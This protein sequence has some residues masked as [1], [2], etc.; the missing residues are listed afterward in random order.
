MPFITHG[1]L[2]IPTNRDYDLGQ[3]L[4]LLLNLMDETEKIPVQAKVVWKTPAGS[5]NFRAVGIGVQFI[6]EQNGSIARS[7]IETYL[8]GSLG[9]DR[10]THTM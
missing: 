4:F 2:F 3:E 7:K 9:S 6:E 10:P 1:G 5:E 8:A